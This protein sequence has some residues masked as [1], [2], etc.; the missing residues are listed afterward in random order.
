MII[1]RDKV[2]GRHAK[3]VLEKKKK[4]TT[5]QQQFIVNISIIYLDILKAL[6][7]AHE[8]HVPLSLVRLRT[9]RI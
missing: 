3:A 7:V 1:K 8:S 6:H 2:T 5:Q 9:R 4:K